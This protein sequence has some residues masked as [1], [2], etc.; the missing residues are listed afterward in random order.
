MLSARVQRGAASVAPCTLLF[1][2]GVYL[3]DV[4]SCHEI[5]RAQRTRVGELEIAGR[6]TSGRIKG[7]EQAISKLVAAQGV[8]ER[9]A[10]VFT[11]PSMDTPSPMHIPA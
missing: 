9:R 1:L 11:K 3:C 5:L 8:I 4:C 7:L 2:A 6:P 10:G